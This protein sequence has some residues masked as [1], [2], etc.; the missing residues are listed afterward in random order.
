MCPGLRNDFEFL[1]EEDARDNWISSWGGGYGESS[2][3][4]EPRS[5]RCPPLILSRRS[6]LEQK[7]ISFLILELARIGANTETRDTC[8]NQIF[9]NLTVFQSDFRLKKC[10]I[11]T[12][13]PQHRCCKNL[14]YELL[15]RDI[16]YLKFDGWDFGRRASLL[17]N[18]ISCHLGTTLFHGSFSRYYDTCIIDNRHTSLHQ[19]RHQ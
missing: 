9:R 14:W 11:Y 1:V 7:L 5:V 2:D 15:L 3:G 16:V 12:I 8:L 13:P 6:T 19:H 18:L 17:Q 4:D 10:S